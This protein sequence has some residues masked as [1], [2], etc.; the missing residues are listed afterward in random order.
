MLDKGDS[1]GIVA[2]SDAMDEEYR[3]QIRELENALYDIGL[4]TVISEYVFKDKDTKISPGEKADEINR[5]FRNERIK[6]VFDVSGGD[7]ANSILEYLDYDLIEDSDRLFFGYSD[8]TAV[9]NAIYTRCGKETCLY[10]VRNLIYEHQERQMADF[11]MSIIGGED[12]LYD[13]H[14]EFV[15]G[16]SM[17]GVVIGGNTRCFLKLAGTPYMP[18]FK[19]KILFLEGL[20]GNEE[21]VRAYF[22]QLKHMGAFSEINGV[23]LGTFTGLMSREDITAADILT[24]VCNDSKLPVAVTDEIGHG[25]DSKAIIIGR[26]LEL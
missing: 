22:T 12:D 11:E 19:H 14:Y 20:S 3:D 15:Q 21:R 16:D 18:S 6:A 9:L 23:L 4:N 5:M 13:F 17:K 26:E 24:E 2:C 1:V 8:V 10:Q 25:A 7:S